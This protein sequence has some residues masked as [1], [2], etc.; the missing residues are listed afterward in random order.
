M[1]IPYDILGKVFVGL[2]F[3]A[4][5]VIG[6]ALLLGVYSFRKKKI[7]FPNFVLFILYLFYGPAK[8]ICRVFGIK[9]TLV[10]EILVEVRNA[11]M[12]DQ[13]RKVKNGRVVFLP[14]CLRHPECKAR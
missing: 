13:F 12:L 10:D 2:A 11:V 8:W 6:M 1:Q 4:I 5:L 7:I 3:L 14:Q 9:D